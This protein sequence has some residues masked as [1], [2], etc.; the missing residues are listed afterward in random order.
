MGS[1]LI[2]DDFF[3][4]LQ[5]PGRAFTLVRIASARLL[6]EFHMPAVEP[7]IRRS[8]YI[9]G[10]SQG[11]AAIVRLFRKRRPAKPQP[12]GDSHERTTAARPQAYVARV[13]ETAA[14]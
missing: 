12:Q 6:A 10:R 1:A 9:V 7:A 3:R 8:R 2:R 5:G 14:T 4:Q 11:G 13:G